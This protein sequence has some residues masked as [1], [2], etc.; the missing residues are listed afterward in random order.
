MNSSWQP[1]EARKSKARMF[2]RGQR[3][4]GPERLSR[5]APNAGTPVVW[6]TAAAAAA[7]D[8]VLV[9]ILLQKNKANA[10]PSRD[11]EGTNHEKGINNNK[12]LNYAHC[13]RFAG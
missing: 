6:A 13:S 4:N 9:P 11:K 5:P 1:G 8:A 3:K 7:P 2:P 12:F 10:F